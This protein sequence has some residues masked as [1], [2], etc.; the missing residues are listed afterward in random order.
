V[1]DTREIKKGKTSDRKF[2]TT[3]RT[4]V[5][6]ASPS[7]SSLREKEGKKKGKKKRERTN[8]HERRGGG[9]CKVQYGRVTAFPLL[10]EK[11]HKRQRREGKKKKNKAADAATGAPGPFILFLCLRRG[12]Q[13]KGREIQRKREEREDRG[14]RGRDGHT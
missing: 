2:T 7:I 12:S 14:E 4:L 13:K 8:R 3:A 9:H 6:S 5:V 1:T 10:L 11:R